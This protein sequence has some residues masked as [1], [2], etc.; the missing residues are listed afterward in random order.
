MD[1][2]KIY[3]AI[4]GVG[5]I[6]L[7]I[8][9]GWFF[10]FRGSGGPSGGNTDQKLTLNIWG[11]FETSEGMETF[12]AEFNKN[13]PNVEVSYSQHSVDTYESD[14][15]NALAINE[16][17]DIFVIHNDWLPKYQN[18]LLPAP[19]DLVSLRDYKNSFVDTVYSD[20]VLEDKIWAAPITM[21]SLALYYN[22]D[23]LGSA[24]IAV[25]ATTWQEL[26]KQSERITNRGS[27]SFFN[28]S[29]VALGTNANIN[30]AVDILY[31]LMLQDRVEPYSSDFSQ[32]TFDQ[33]ITQ[34]DGSSFFPASDAL[35]FY[36]SFANPTSD[37]YTWNSR[38]NYSIDA[39]ANGEL[40]YMYGYYYARDLI[41]QKA[42]NLNYDIAPVPQPDNI[43]TL[44][45]FANYWGFAVSK[46]TKNP[47]TSWNFIKAM[48]GKNTLKKYYE[49]NKQPS[50]RKDI[51][52]EQIGDPEIGVFASANL[53]AKSFYKKDQVKADSIF[54]TMIDDIILRGRSIENAIS[55]AAQKISALSQ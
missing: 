41:A 17:P 50:P 54:Q 5:A 28:R 55:T 6:L 32:P 22:K 39:F 29:G 25:P 13:N 45:N 21:D 20:F 7:V 8:F 34:K 31:L 4:G 46:Q 12:I 24:S 42:P 40:G 30:R 10:F 38:S 11:I 37:N 26:K 53:T 16:A 23:I 36:T 47:N 52:N 35:S 33:A 51:I 9:L 3:W 48:T 14:L 27:G 49:V 44:V 15:I 18:K 1:K 43:Q 19:D 2:T